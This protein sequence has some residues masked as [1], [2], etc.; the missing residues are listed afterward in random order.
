MSM[1]KSV[2]DS[3][4]SDQNPTFVEAAVA[5]QSSGIFVVARAKVWSGRSSFPGNSSRTSPCRSTLKEGDAIVRR[6]TDEIRE[7]TEV[8]AQPPKT[9]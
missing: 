9:S 4:W 2:R 6:G 5:R 8:N 3:A 7:G 1:A